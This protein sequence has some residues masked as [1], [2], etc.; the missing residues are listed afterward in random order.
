MKSWAELNL[1]LS[2]A[3]PSAKKR[4]QREMVGIV[5]PESSYVPQPRA[6]FC[7]RVC[8]LMLVHTLSVIERDR[9][10]DIESLRL[11]KT[12]KIIWPNHQ[13]I[14]S[15]P[16]SH[17]PQC[18]LH[19]FS[20][21]LWIDAKIFGHWS[22]FIPFMNIILLSWI[23]QKIFILLFWSILRCEWEKSYI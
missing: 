6:R 16:T 21:Q 11:E 7:S 9:S 8:F 12:A 1:L 17:V 5:W 22:A 10:E 4:I 15:V 19:I 3:K 2:F 23:I 14:T 13:P 20:K 18:Y